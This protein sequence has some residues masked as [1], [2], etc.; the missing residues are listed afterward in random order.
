MSVIWNYTSGSVSENIVS[1]RRALGQYS[2]YYGHMKIGISNAPERRWAEHQAERLKEGDSWSYMVVI[3]ESNTLI[4]ARTAEKQLIDYANSCGY[5]D[6]VWNQRSGEKGGV[7]MQFIY[8]LVDDGG[9]AQQNICWL[10]STGQYSQVAMELVRALGQYAK[11]ENNKVKY[12]KVG[13]TNDPQRR[14]KEHLRERA[15]H[16]DSWTRMIVIYA[17]S[18][19][20]SARRA[21][22]DLIDH[23]NNR[24]PDTMFNSISGSDLPAPS[25]YFTYVLL[26]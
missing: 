23:G 7:G 9:I 18:S 4:E 25:T 24:Y 11:K 21:E 10:Y 2:R 8:V 1:L 16:N 15:R 5:K 17:T 20:S 6:K 12:I 22:K 19:A 14:W 3:H 13:R 26:D